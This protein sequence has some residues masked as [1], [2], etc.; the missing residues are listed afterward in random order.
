MLL[1]FKGPF[2]SKRRPFV[3]PRQILGFPPPT[4]S[5]QRDGASVGRFR[6]S[7]PSTAS[8]C[9]RGKVH[10]AS[11][12]ASGDRLKA[13]LSGL[14][15]WK[16]K[17]LRSE[18]SLETWFLLQLLQK[19]TKEVDLHLS[20]CPQ[21]TWGQISQQIHPRCWHLGIYHANHFANLPGPRRTW[22]RK[23]SQLWE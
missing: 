7:S 11:T 23:L 5:S 3:K 19:Y 2:T 18:V 9:S 6:R 22:A 21:A 1:K 20:V 12:K 16:L 4:R 15:A 10:K 13:Q 14:A 17:C 8:A